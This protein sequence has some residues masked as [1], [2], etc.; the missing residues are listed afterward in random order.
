MALSNSFFDI[1]SPKLFFQAI[2]RATKELKQSEFK[3]TEKL[4]FVIMGLNHLREWIAPKNT[5]LSP[6]KVFSQK[7][8]KLKAH[9]TIRRLCN[10]SKH[11]DP[12]GGVMS[13]P[14]PAMIDDWP[15]VDSVNNF[16]YGPP[17]GYLVD[18]KDL[19]EVISEVIRYYDDHWFSQRGAT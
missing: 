12:F 16:D 3:N 5:P 6:A 15:D 4:M 14:P 13:M 19:L 8:Y 7:I 18:G 11:M 1:S 17:R 2:R 10:H 9:K